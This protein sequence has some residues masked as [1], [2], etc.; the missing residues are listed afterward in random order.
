[1]IDTWE[2]NKQCSQSSLLII[3]RCTYHN[4]LM[5]MYI[6]IIALGI[7][8]TAMSSACTHLA[9]QDQVKPHYH[10]HHIYHH[11]HHNHLHNNQHYCIII[12][13]WSIRYRGGC[14]KLIRT[15]GTYPRWYSL[16]YTSS[17]TNS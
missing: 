3:L 2:K 4:H 7:I 8:N 10:H 6:V 9:G 5:I 17:A 13:W 1:M 12:G 11:H 14:R 15:S 16:S